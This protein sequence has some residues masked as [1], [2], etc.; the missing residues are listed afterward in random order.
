M[1]VCWEFYCHLYWDA[2]DLRPRI[3]CYDISY[4]SCRRGRTLKNVCQLFSVKVGKFDIFLV[5]LACVTSSPFPSFLLVQCKLLKLN[6][7]LF[8][9]W[10]PQFFVDD[11]PHFTMVSSLSHG[12]LQISTDWNSMNF[13][14][15][16]VQTPFIL[17][18]HSSPISTLLAAE[19]PTASRHE[20]AGPLPSC[21]GS[22]VNVIPQARCV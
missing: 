17:G 13:I 18:L 9:R 16:L 12:E 14:L 5:E 11:V 2:E 3:L 6:L 10:H 22:L 1:V 19:L 4:W 20:L 21:F 7:D 15:L 8:A